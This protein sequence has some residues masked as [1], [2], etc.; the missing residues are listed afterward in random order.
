VSFGIRDIKVVQQGF[1][2]AGILAAVLPLS[3]AELGS[4]EGGLLVTC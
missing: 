4:L 2:R 3:G 1:V